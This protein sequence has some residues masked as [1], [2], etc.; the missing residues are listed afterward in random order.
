M[1]ENK[2]Q[3]QN[4]KDEKEKIEIKIKNLKIINKNK[5][6]GKANE[7]IRVSHNFNDE[8]EDIIKK[9]VENDQDESPISKPKTTKLITKHNGWRKMKEDII[10]YIFP[11]KEKGRKMKNKRGQTTMLIFVAILLL[12]SLVLFYLVHGI[13][14]IKIDEA[15]STNITLG[16]VNLANINSQTYGVWADSVLNNSDWWGLGTIFGLILG[17]FLSAYFTRNS[18][19][20]MGIVLD[21][22]IIVGVFVFSL[23]LRDVYLTLMEALAAAGETFLEVFLPNTSQFIIN[24]PVYVVIIGAIMMILFHSSIPRRSEETVQRGGFSSLGG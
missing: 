5:N 23:Y 6:V 4:L 12:I 21:I 9:R 16:Q 1:V 3:I 10:N 15:L 11:I 22:F 20:K 24:L 2:E 18:F 7:L 8:L 13:I 14:V 19:P 17:L